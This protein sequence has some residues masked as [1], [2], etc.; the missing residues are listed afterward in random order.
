MK[1]ILSYYQLQEDLNKLVDWS[2]KW[3]MLFNT[4][5]CSVLHLGY[6]N[7]HYTYSMHD[8]IQNKRVNL[9]NTNCERDL[10]VYID[11][12]LKF[13]HHIKTQVN[14]A[15][16]MLGMMRRSFTFLDAHTFKKLFIS[17]VRPHLEYCAVVHQPRLAKDKQMI[18]NVLRRASKMIPGL[19]NLPYNQRLMRLQI[20]SM[21][22]R[23]HEV[24]SSKYLNG[25]IHITIVVHYLHLKI[26]LS[27]EVINTSSRNN[28]PILISESIS[29]RLELLTNG[30][31][32]LT[33]LFVQQ[34]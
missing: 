8:H 15:N 20:P 19:N 28:L 33:K 9:K 3:N 26:D 10:G 25:F 24:T 6:N 5:K 11:K 29:L 4:D 12:D 7:Q 32:S 16:Q 1:N 17:I 21:Q 27:P 30:T 13:S 34:V 23:L 18:E 31:L 14:K 2:R 22:Y